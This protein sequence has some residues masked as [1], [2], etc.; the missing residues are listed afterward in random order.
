MLSLWLI[1][2]GQAKNSFSVILTGTLCLPSLQ[3]PETQC[4]QCAVRGRTCLPQV[5]LLLNKKHPFLCIWSDLDL[6]ASTFLTQMKTA[7][8]QVKQRELTICLLVCISHERLKNRNLPQPWKVMCQAAY[9]H[10]KTEN[11]FACY[12]SVWCHVQASAKPTREKQLI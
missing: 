11:R 5:A 4:D 9:L 2:T 8:C 1:F 6:W 10:I 12:F 3:G 7:L